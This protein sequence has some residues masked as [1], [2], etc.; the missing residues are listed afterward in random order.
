MRVVDQQPL[1]PAHFVDHAAISGAAAI[2]CSKKGFAPGSHVRQFGHQSRK[3]LE[4]RSN[5]LRISTD[6]AASC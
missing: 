6:A 4:Q 5:N 3:L 1:L 2:L